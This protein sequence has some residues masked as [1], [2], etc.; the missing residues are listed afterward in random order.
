[1]SF[2]S[3]SNK[4]PSPGVPDGYVLVKKLPEKGPDEKDTKS[5]TAAPASTAL[6]SIPRLLGGGQA[7]RPNGLKPITVKLVARYDLIGSAASVLNQV[8][9]VSP[10]AVADFNSFAAL[11]D[12]QRTKSLRVHF[13]VLS[14]AAIAGFSTYGLAW[15]PS[16]LGAYNSLPDLLTAQVKR[17]PYLIGGGTATR[18][19][20]L[21][22]S[23]TGFHSMNVSL[24]MN[25][26]TGDTATSNLVGGAWVATSNTTALV[27]WI[28]PYIESF[29]PSVSATLT[30]FIEY[31]VEFK[32]RT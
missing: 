32:S 22:C 31:H 29:G 10:I 1:M 8:Q 2:F 23:E 11:Y 27:G 9:P 28:K 12:L 5:Q 18:E 20:S 25:K 16:N 30:M 15:D 7:G 21:S 24:P 19:P 6:S 4:Q 13:C 14:S 26:I 3:T 17:G